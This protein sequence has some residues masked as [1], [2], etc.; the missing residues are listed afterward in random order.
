[1]PEFDK[2]RRRSA[3]R[4]QSDA[5]LAAFAQPYVE[6]P[7]D[8]SSSRYAVRL[9]HGVSSADSDKWDAAKPIAIHSAGPF[10]EA[11]SSRATPFPIRDAG[12]QLQAN[13]FGATPYLNGARELFDGFLLRVILGG[14]FW[15]A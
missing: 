5:L 6:H 14:Q 1:M 11:P 9:S 7:T 15:A 12:S 4:V 8:Y 10:R 3:F 13:S 2:S